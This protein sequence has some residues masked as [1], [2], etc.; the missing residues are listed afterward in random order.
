MKP[1]LQVPG[2]DCVGDG[3]KEIERRENWTLGPH[4]GRAWQDGGQAAAVW[5]AGIGGKKL[6]EVARS[7]WP[8]SAVRARGHSPGPTWNSSPAG[9][10]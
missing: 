4:P 10:R 9:F 6:P 3:G 7:C 8:G 5:E 2:L 1:V